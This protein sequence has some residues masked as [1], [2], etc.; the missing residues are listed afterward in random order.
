MLLNGIFAASQQRSELHFLSDKMPQCIVPSRWLHRTATVQI[1]RLCSSSVSGRAKSSE[2]LMIKGGNKKPP[3]LY[4]FLEQTV[5][6][7]PAATS[8][9]PE[10]CWSTS[11]RGAGQGSHCRHPP[12]TACCIVRIAPLSV[13]PRVHAERTYAHGASGAGRDGPGGA[14]GASRPQRLLHGAGSRRLTAGTHHTRDRPARLTG[15]PADITYHP[16]ETTDTRHH[17]MV[18]TAPPPPSAQ[19]P[20][21]EPCTALIT[22][23]GAPVCPTPNSSSARGPMPTKTARRFS[24]DTLARLQFEHLHKQ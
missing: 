18:L 6:M 5:S 9:P 8:A 11:R 3:P 17:E 13:P 15:R 10:Q 1:V 21:S 19:A 22:K 12:V 23:G 24:N 14:G 2:L 4:L 20:C 16:S 7:R